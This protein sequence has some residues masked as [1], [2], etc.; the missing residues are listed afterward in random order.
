MEKAIN[1]I[2]FWGL[3]TYAT[4]T[5]AGIFAI[6]PTAGNVCYDVPYGGKTISEEI[7]NTRK[8]IGDNFN[9]VASPAYNEKFGG[10]TAFIDLNKIEDQGLIVLFDGTFKQ[11]EAIALS[12]DKERRE[13]LKSKKKME[14]RNIR[15]NDNNLVS[16]GFDRLIPLGLDSTGNQYYQNNNVI[17]NNDGFLIEFL[18]AYV[19]PR[20][21]NGIYYNIYRYTEEINC[22]KKLISDVMHSLNNNVHVIK[23][24]IDKPATRHF[25]MSSPIGIAAKKYCK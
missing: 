13:Y 2:I 18:T 1:I 16:F 10:E 6:E 8:N 7:I 25:E 23:N 5:S 12:F 22:N 9:V 3:I 4:I 19:E 20:L 14:L 21:E 15:N 11:C 24:I 17:Y